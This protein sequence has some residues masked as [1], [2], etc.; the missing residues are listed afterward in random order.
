MTFADN[1]NG[2]ATISGTPGASTGG[3]YALALSADNGVGAD[4][5]Q[6]FTLNIDQPPS[7]T[8]AASSDFTVGEPD[9]FTV[10]TGGFP[11]P[12]V[13][14]TG[15]LPPGVTFIDN[16][17]G[18]A[19]F[20]GA[21]VAIGNYP[22]NLTAVNGVGD[23]ASQTLALIVGQ[24]PVVTT[25]AQ[26]SF[27]VG[28]S[29]TFVFRTVGY[30]TAALSETGAL[31]SGVTFRNNGN[32]T[33]TL[34]GTAGP[35]TAG[36]YDLTVNASNGF[37]PD[38][39]QAFVLTVL[40]A[41]AIT[42]AANIQFSAGQSDS[43]TITTAG[44]PAAALAQSGALPAG[45]TF[46]DNGDGTATLAGTPTAVGVYPL[47]LGASN[48]VGADA[49]QAFTFTVGSPPAITSAAAAAL[50]VGQSGSFTINT[51][52]FPA[53]ASSQTGAL[54][55]GLSFI[56]NG[57][58]TAT[59]SGTPAVGA[60]GVYSL[61]LDASNGFTPDAT[62]TLTLTV[63]EAP[64]ITS[65]STATFTTGAAGSFT[66]TTGGFPAPS[67]T[68]SGALPA[69]LT[70]LDNGNG[71]ATISGTP[72]DG[73]GGTY[74]L[75]LGAANNVGSAASQALALTVQQAPHITSG[76]G[77]TFLAGQAGSATVT[78]SGFGAATLTESGALPAGLTF[79]D[80]GNATATI[81]GTPAAGSGGTYSLSIDAGNGVGAD[82][83]EPFV[84]TV[85]EAPAIT[86]GSAATFTTGSAGSFTVNTYGFPA[87]SLSKTGRCRRA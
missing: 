32:G 11:A 53:A 42:S 72:A 18:T 40:D 55:N 86:S 54:P 45:V 6:S 35:G 7:F 9:V 68:Q 62:Q 73:T 65:S 37:S 57:N 16:G 39:S 85:Q 63:D 34:L 71:T 44:Y 83:V 27:Q 50:T 76:G 28:S 8:S 41:P 78:A 1:G 21:A 52:G 59:L 56:D 36:V 82:D 10:L 14:S 79:Q 12:T 49:S 70:F 61:A 26:E 58:G 48:G 43:F 17:D 22:L 13:T 74:N 30:P 29:G 77:A 47:T 87:A 3:V 60:D 80:N 5:T 46:T 15:T 51:T 4:A 69:G 25:P 81:A 23:S 31:P 20:S 75:T 19:T 24:P 2:T 67:F 66:I 38:A 84:I 33:A 64:A